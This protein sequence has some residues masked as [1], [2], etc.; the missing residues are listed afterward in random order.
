M[1]VI[2]ALW[3]F[4]KIFK[5]TLDSVF[6]YRDYNS[7]VVEIS[8]IILEGG[9]EKCHYAKMKFIVVRRQTAVAKLLLLK[10][11][12][13]AVKVRNSRIAAAAGQWK[14]FLDKYRRKRRR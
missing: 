11:R 10:A 4:L 2:H 12:R 14:K 7:F 1:P 8:A 5:Q 3:Y 13:P 9:K 6:D